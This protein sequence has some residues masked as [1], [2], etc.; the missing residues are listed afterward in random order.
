MGKQKNRKLKETHI[1]KKN[2][3]FYNK[4]KKIKK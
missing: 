4:R 2:P 3:I 1:K